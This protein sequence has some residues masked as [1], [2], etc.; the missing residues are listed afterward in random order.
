MK[1]RLAPAFEQPALGPDRLGAI[2]NGRI[3]KALRQR[4]CVR[5]KGRVSKR[6]GTLRVCSFR[7]GTRGGTL[8]PV[9]RETLGKARYASASNM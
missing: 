5:K 7:E 4:I 2:V 9:E 3:Q 6:N 1:I 8:V